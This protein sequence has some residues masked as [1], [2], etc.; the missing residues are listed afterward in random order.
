MLL[1]LWL[2][3]NECIRDKQRIRLSSRAVM[4]ALRQVDF[5]IA[6]LA[7]NKSEQVRNDEEVWAN[8]TFWKLALNVR[9]SLD[10]DVLGR[11]RLI[12]GWDKCVRPLAQC[13]FYS[14][15]TDNPGI[16]NGILWWFRIEKK[17]C[18]CVCHTLWTTEGVRRS[19]WFPS[20]NGAHCLFNINGIGISPLW[21]YIWVR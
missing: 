17:D 18:F 20:K 8:N 2:F 1:L 16:G 3:L 7:Q 13:F 19:Q 21:L 10:N 11:K 14:L 9:V 6:C 12:L 4:G 15:S 5:Q